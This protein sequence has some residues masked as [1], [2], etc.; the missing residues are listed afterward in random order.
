M[1]VRENSENMMSQ[2]KG[3]WNTMHSAVVQY[4]RKCRHSYLSMFSF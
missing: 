4:A 2:D 1:E 3:L